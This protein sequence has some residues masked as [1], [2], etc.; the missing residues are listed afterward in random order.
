MGTIFPFD[1]VHRILNFRLHAIKVNVDK[2]LTV[3]GLCIMSTIIFFVAFLVSRVDG[4]QGGGLRSEYLI[5]TARN[6]LGLC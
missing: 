2:L 4:I 6:E 3:F 1:L 5:V